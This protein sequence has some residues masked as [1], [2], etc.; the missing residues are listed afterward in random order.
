ML[1]CNSCA[2]F[3]KKNRVKIKNQQSNTWKVA[4][5]KNIGSICCFS[6]IA[7]DRDDNGSDPGWWDMDYRKMVEGAMERVLTILMKSSISRLND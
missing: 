5:L 4:L 3:L 2:I 1:D 6:W 7:S